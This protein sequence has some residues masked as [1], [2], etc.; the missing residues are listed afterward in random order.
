[1]I[2]A[3]EV[4]QDDGGDGPDFGIQAPGVPG[5]RSVVTISQI[6]R[7]VRDEFGAEA[8]R[9][10]VHVVVPVARDGSDPVQVIRWSLAQLHAG[11]GLSATDIDY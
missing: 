1:M 7:C 3:G 8:F 11:K 9:E 5:E 6:A 4:A 2:A 10:F